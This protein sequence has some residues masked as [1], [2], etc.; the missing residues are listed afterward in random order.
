MSANAPH[1]D[2]PHNLE[3]ATLAAVERIEADCG[4]LLAFAVQD[5]QT[6]KK[7]LYRPDHRCQTASVIKFPMLIHVA[8]AVQEGLLDWNE[9]LTLSAEEKVGGSGVLTQLTAGTEWTLRDLCVL[10]TIVSDNT[11]TNMVIERVGVEPINARMRALGLPLT[12]LYR[13]SY[14]PDTDAS[15]EHGLGMTTPTEMLALLRLLAE[16]K[17][18]SP[19]LSQ[20]LLTIMEAQ[21]Y[22]DCIPRYL[23]ED[24]KYAGKTGAINA[25]RNDVGVVVAPDGRRFALALFCQQLTKVQWTAE[26]PGLIAL[27]QLARCLLLPE[28]K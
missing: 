27:A 26:N 25:V 21:N 5:L 28:G 9:K 8:L 3:A 2:A 15:R 13:K 18:G 23:P 24:W 4:G 20:E 10:M 19:A 12:T 14:A 17:I 7:F 1:N 16:G 22:R 6:G 11:A